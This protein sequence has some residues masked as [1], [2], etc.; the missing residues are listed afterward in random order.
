MS[1]YSMSIFF[2][3]DILMEN[4]YRVFA[5]VPNLVIRASNTY[6]KQFNFKVPSTDM[7]LGHNLMLV[8]ALLLL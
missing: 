5:Q 1:K 2:F 6:C 3:F 4:T 7:G 8:L